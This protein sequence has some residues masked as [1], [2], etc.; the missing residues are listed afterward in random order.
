MVIIVL[1]YILVKLNFY[2][3]VIY[4]RPGTP[5]TVKHNLIRFAVQILSKTHDNGWP[6]IVRTSRVPP[7]YYRSEHI[8]GRIGGQ[9]KGKGA[10]TNAAAYRFATRLSSSVQAKENEADSL[11]QHPFFRPARAPNEK[12]IANAHVINASLQSHYTITHITTYAA[13]I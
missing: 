8:I 13:K 7:H 10:G 6:P 12:P 9:A 3:I 2:H 11:F 4:R 5:V 1:Y